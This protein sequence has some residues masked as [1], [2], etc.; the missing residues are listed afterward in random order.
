[1]W[2]YIQSTVN[3]KQEE[4]ESWNFER[5]FIPHYVSCVMCHVSPVTCQQKK[6]HIYFDFLFYPSEKIGQSCGASRWRV[7]YQRGLPRLIFT[8]SAWTVNLKPKLQ[9]WDYAL[10]IVCHTVELYCQKFWIMQLLVFHRFWGRWP[11]SSWNWLI[12]SCHLCL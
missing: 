2:K 12:V 11:V 6:L 1:M 3:P 8:G 5:M 7:C 9:P 10:H 4:L